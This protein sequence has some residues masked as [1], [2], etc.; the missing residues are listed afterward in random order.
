MQS[1]PFFSGL[2]WNLLYQRKIPPPYNPC[3]NQDTITYSS[4]F[5]EEFTNMPI[6]SVEDGSALRERQSDTF[7]GFTYDK[8][9]HFEDVYFDEAESKQ[10]EGLTRPRSKK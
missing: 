1:H 3:K 8:D 2:D 10:Y 5:E 7:Q 4:N 9:S 6:Q